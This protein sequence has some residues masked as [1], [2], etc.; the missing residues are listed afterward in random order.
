MKFLVFLLWAERLVW[1]L[2][3]SDLGLCKCV[4]DLKF[5]SYFIEGV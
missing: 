5:V 3:M 2:C 1:I 4:F